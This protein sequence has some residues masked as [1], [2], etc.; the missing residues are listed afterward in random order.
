MSHESWRNDQVDFQEYRYNE[1]FS[2]LFD[3]ALCYKKSSY[4]SIKL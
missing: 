2:L 3:I 1:I 4:V